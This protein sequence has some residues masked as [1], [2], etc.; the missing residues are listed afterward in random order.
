MIKTGLTLSP[1][2]GI[3][4]V[5]LL[6]DHPDIDLKWVDA[7]GAHH[8]NDLYDELTG[9]APVIPETPDFD[10]IDLYIGPADG[11]TAFRMGISGAPH[12][13]AIYTGGQVPETAV[14]GVAEYNRKA[15]VRGA[16]EAYVPD[17]LTLLTS[18]ALMPLAKNLMVRPEITGTALLPASVVAMPGTPLHTE[19]FG[20]AAA[21]LAELQ[22]SCN[23][24]YEV[25]PVTGSDGFSAVTLGMEQ[26]MPL[27]DIVPLYRDFYDDH[28]H[29]VVLEDRPVTRAMTA[30][31]N[32]TVIALRHD[33]SKLWV[34]AACDARF[35]LSAGLPVHLLNLLFGL[36]ECTGL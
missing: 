24:R 31:T 26:S 2:T 33:G 6:L 29:V 14:L 36:D 12:L 3:D 32:K 21:I 16:R 15:L 10:T 11:K 4:L 20:H 23:A 7:D 13:K 18:L 9:E 22:S 1:A 27:R 19:A 28:R 34:T 5:R 35:K 8:V 30:G 17:A 25:V